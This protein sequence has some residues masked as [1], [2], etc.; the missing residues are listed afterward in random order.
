MIKKYID[1]NGNEKI[2]KYDDNKYNRNKEIY[3]L[4]KRKYYYQKKGEL[5]KVKTLDILIN[6]EKRKEKL[7][8]EE[9]EN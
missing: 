3:K 7:N 9:I 5:D 2:Y 4:Q 6:I 1:K 8:N